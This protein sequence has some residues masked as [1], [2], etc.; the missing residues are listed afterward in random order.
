MYPVGADQVKEGGSDGVGFISS[1][2]GVAAAL[3]QA[4]QER[5]LR[6][7]VLELDGVA[8]ATMTKGLCVNLHESGT[9]GHPGDLLVSLK[10]PVDPSSTGRFVFECG[11]AYCLDPGQVYWVVASV[12]TPGVD[13]RYRVQS[14]KDLDARLGGG[15]RFLAIP[16]GGTVRPLTGGPTFTAEFSGPLPPLAAISA[17]RNKVLWTAMLLGIIG[18]CCWDLLPRNQFP[19]LRLSS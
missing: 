3:A 19:H 12:E 6:R 10:G 2:M 5:M 18:F 14:T 11:E 15:G 13:F 16:A 8:S 7:V 4:D 17:G 1:E 9:D